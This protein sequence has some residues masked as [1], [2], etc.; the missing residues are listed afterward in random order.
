MIRRREGSLLI[1]SLWLVTLLSLLAIAIARYLSLEIRLTKYRAARDE[2]TILARDGVFLALQQLAEDA[3]Q[4]EKNDAGESSELAYDWRGDDWA[5]LTAV[6]TPEPSRSITLQILD[7]QR[8]LNLNAATKEQLTQLTGSTQLAEEIVD[9]RDEPDPAE[10]R[11]ASNPPYLAKNA[12]FAAP[13]ELGDLPEMT[14]EAYN[15]MKDSTTPYAGAGEPLNINT[16]TPAVLRALGVTE[17]TVQLLERFRQDGG[18][19]QGGLVVLETLKNEAGVNLTGTPDGALLSGPLFGVTSNT[20]TVVSEGRIER[21]PVRVRVEAVVRR[22]GCPGNAP[23]C[24]I[25]W[26][27]G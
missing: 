20:F 2:A 19:R 23:T 8:K 27:A 13:E 17:S 12:P 9:A 6:A 16:V 4:G 18:F 15:I 21:P 26:R 11:P 7:E 14:P 5:Q 10:D 22:T 25:A 1:I 24:V 3:K